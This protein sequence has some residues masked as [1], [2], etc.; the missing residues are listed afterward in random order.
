[1]IKIDGRDLPT[2]VLGE[3]S[4]TRVGDWVMAWATR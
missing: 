2:T 1:V 4:T 3:D